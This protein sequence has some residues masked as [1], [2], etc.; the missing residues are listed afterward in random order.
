MT[1]YPTDL[2]QAAGTA[3]DRR[4]GS[5][6][7]GEPVPA[8]GISSATRHRR[9]PKAQHCLVAAVFAAAWA[10]ILL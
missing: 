6:A 5:L 2:R 7:C 10:F 4:N 3:A 1:R 8:T 9:L